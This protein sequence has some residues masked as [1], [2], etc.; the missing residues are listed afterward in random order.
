MRILTMLFDEININD[1]GVLEWDEFTTF[2]IDKATVLNSMKSKNDEIKAYTP[3][4]L[5]LTKKFENLLTKVI[6][7]E[8]IDR[9]AFLEEGS[10]EIY[11]LNHETGAFN[12]KPLKVTPLKEEEGLKKT[13][14]NIKGGI[15]KHAEKSMVLDMIYVKEKKSYF[16]LTSSDDCAIRTWRYSSNGFLNTNA[17][18]EGA[19]FFSQAQVCIAWFL[20]SHV[21]FYNLE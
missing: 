14:N 6:Y 17:E 9:V 19:I 5:K 10:D 3:V 2:I 21:L 8:D 20:F 4:R 13:K 1:N 12:P 15:M 11:F 7:L 16:L 18:E